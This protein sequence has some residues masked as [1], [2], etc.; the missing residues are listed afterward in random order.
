MAEDGV[1]AEICNSTFMLYSMR[2]P[3]TDLVRDCCAVYNAWIGEYVSAAPKRL[4]GSA[5]IALEDVAWA[6]AELERASA[7]RA[8]TFPPETAILGGA[9]YIALACFSAISPITGS[10]YISP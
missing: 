10:L 3:D 7:L 8:P 2:I 1:W 9:N 4:I 5:M 6:T